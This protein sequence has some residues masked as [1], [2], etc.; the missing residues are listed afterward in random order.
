[1]TRARGWESVSG[2]SERCCGVP[3][4][5]RVK[6]SAVSSKTTS[7]DLVFT[8]AGTSTRVER[9]VRVAGPGSPSCADPLRQ[10]KDRKRDKQR[11]DL[12]SRFIVGAERLKTDR[13]SCGIMSVASRQRIL[14]GN[15]PKFFSIA[16]AQPKSCPDPEPSSH[17]DLKFRRR[18]TKHIHQG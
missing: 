15:A 3:S 5:V 17:A 9:T 1:M 4:S 7:P 18:L 10:A 11:A 6:S 13:R 12:I 8:M 16:F 2:S 14:G